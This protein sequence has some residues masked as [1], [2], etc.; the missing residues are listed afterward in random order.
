MDQRLKHWC[1]KYLINKQVDPQT[2]DINSIYD[3]SLNYQ[4]NK[5][6]IIAYIKPLIGDVEYEEYAEIYK[7]KK[8]T[9]IKYQYIPKTV[10]PIEYTKLDKKV[11][12]FDTESDKG[13][14]TL[15]ADNEG[16]H[17]IIHEVQDILKFLNN[18]CYRNT[19][20]FF[21]NLGYDTCTILKHLSIERQKEIANTNQ[22]E[23]GKYRI[24]IIP[25]KQLQI[26]KIDGK[27][28]KQVT[29]FYDIYKYYQ[30]GNLEE[31]YSE[32][33]KTGYVKALDASKGF[34]I[35]D[36]DLDVIK[37][38]IDDSKACQRLAQYIVDPCY[39]ITPVKK[40]ISP[41]SIAKM[42]MRQHL[43]QP[44]MYI[45]TRHNEMALSAYNG[46]RFEV[47]KRG[48]FDKIHSYDIRSAYPN[49]MQDLYE[50]SGETFSNKIYHPD[51]TY[52]YFK[53][54]VDIPDMLIPPVRHLLADKKILI[55]PTGKIKDIN[56][57][58]GEYEILKE[59]DAKI[60]IKKATHLFNVNERKPLEYVKEIYEE[61][62]K[63]KKLGDPRQLILKLILNSMY[64]C[65][66]QRTP[67]ILE[68]DVTDN[69]KIGIYHCIECGERTEAVKMCPE[70]YGDIEVNYIKKVL[71]NGQ[72]FNPVFATEITSRVRCRLFKESVK[73]SQDILMYATDSISAVKKLRLK[74]GEG[75]GEWEA[76]E[77][78][79]GLI[80]GS[81][82]YTLL[83]RDGSLYKNKFR[84]F[85]KFDIIQGMKES[86]NDKVSF[87]KKRMLKLKESIRQKRHDEFNTM[88]GITKELDI[89]FD[90]KRIW[91]EKAINAQYLL[92]NQIESKPWPL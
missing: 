10:Q 2:V 29:T 9:G 59:Y 61:R 31:T 44:Y 18:R 55:F 72:F 91:A 13:A 1:I 27:K 89:N 20:N 70:C 77:N 38:C 63:L 22:T 51:A 43:H 30:V 35:E 65:F 83:N 37:Y 46:A 25:E 56:L 90:C 8:E 82:V 6:K 19:V 32:M 57:T 69:D 33:F 74:I 41:A 47:L 73:R 7:V 36:I 67:R 12:G 24:K 26:G 48:W 15:A 87:Y 81:G 45:P 53:A 76:K 3:S 16:K 28:T 34:P 39:L 52:S 40:F 5:E 17:A 60:E 4:E 11:L 21:F 50:A 80:V 42:S 88:L 64:G 78:L 86:I 23:I 84:G 68:A 66:I 75:L 58:K 85:G 92:N 71:T 49:E 54:D 14:A 62:M 79:K